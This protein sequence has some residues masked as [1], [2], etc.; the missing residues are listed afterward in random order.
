MA[1]VLLKALDIL[2]LFD[3][4]RPEWA[5]H[6]VARQLALPTST[7]HRLLASLR[8][9]GYVVRV[10]GG[11]YRLGPASVALGLRAGDQPVGPALRSAMERV[12]A[13][14]G[15][16]ALVA[17]RDPGGNG[18]LILDRIESPH[19]LRIA[20]EVG[21]VCPLHAGAASKALLAHLPPAEI[22][23][24]VSG[25][26]PRIGPR[27]IT[28]RGM[29]LRD[30]EGVRRLGHAR[31]RE[32]ATEGGW[33]VASPVLGAGGEAQAVLGM[34][35]PVARHGDAAEAGAVAA[36]SRAVAGAG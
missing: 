16:T 25:P 11:R 9:R 21:H 8:S 2:A 19:R 4:N 24:V 22:E 10:A 29:L 7:A 18:L 23:R 30:L 33:A 6:E 32:E 20:L 1:K 15:E 17:V 12:A 3:R 36:V 27:T 13:E 28:D 35:A 31:S 34:I 26:L 14:T 5:E